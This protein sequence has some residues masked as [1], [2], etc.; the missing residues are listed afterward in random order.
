MPRF[1]IPNSAV[2]V[3]DDGTKTVMICGEDALHIVKSLRM[4]AG[5]KLDVC[6]MG[7]REYSCVI[8]DVG[9]TVFAE[10][11]DERYSDTEPPYT[12][13]L[14]QALVK[15]DKFDTV[16]QKAVECGVSKIIPV[17]TDRC[18][19]RLD[20]KGAAKKAE[21]WQRIAL[22]AAKQCGRSIIPEI[23]ELMT[24]KEAVADAS[25]ADIPLFCYEA[26]RGYTLSDALANTKAE[27]TVAI[28]IG[29][30]GG[31]SVSEAKHAI[32]K[33]M[34]CVGLGKRILRTETASSFVLACLCYEFEL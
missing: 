3:R 1:F 18:V 8:T 17:I 16:V 13:V 5:E 7:R 27:P 25:K 20:K 6:D 2:G 34:K 26:E 24:F 33:G 12:A 15:G 19:V 32:E 4:K 9:E 23:G 10:V 21:R 22:E 28:V 14:Y 31:F 30:E 11:T 29:S